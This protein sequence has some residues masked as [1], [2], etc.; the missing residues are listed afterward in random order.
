[1]CSIA[2][3]SAE[4]VS[5]ITGGTEADSRSFTLDPQGPPKLSLAFRDRQVQTEALT[6]GQ[7]T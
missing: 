6:A 3:T 4:Y 2:S 5:E 1:M 7:P